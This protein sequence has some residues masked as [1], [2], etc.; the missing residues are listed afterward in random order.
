MAKDHALSFS[1]LVVSAGR[2]MTLSNFFDNWSINHP[3]EQD[4]FAAFLKRDGWAGGGDVERVEIVTR[5]R[6]NGK[7]FVMRDLSFRPVQS[8]NTGRTNW[9]VHRKG[10]R[11]VWSELAYLDAASDHRCFI[12]RFPGV[13]ANG[14]VADARP[15]FDLAC[16]LVFK[17]L[18][19][20]ETKQAA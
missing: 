10:Q 4:A 1:T 12:V 18:C 5:I 19:K 8:Q 11:G 9:T 17:T 13:R 2:E 3:A 20:A 15:S 7:A 16:A 14:G 6:H